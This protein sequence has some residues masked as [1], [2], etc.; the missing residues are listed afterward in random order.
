MVGFRG[1]GF[2]VVGSKVWGLGFKAARAQGEFEHQ[3]LRA[4]ALEESRIDGFRA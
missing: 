2:R 1:L 3:G 4:Q